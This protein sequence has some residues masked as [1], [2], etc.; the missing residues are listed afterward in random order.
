MEEADEGFILDCSVTMT[1]CF[2]DEASPYADGVLRQLAAAQAF[3]PSIWPL[4]L[5]N[6]TLVGERRTR[7]DEARSSRFLSLLSNLPIIVEIPPVKRRSA[8]LSISRVPTTYRL[9]MLPISNWPSGAAYLWLVST[10][11]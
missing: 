8:K 4:E 2:D 11:S 6:A 1:W 10:A 7:L 3:V 5:A 9:M